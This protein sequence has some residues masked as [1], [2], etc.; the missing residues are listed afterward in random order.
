MVSAL[1]HTYD[2]VLFIGQVKNI[3][4]LGTFISIH[5]LGVLRYGKKKKALI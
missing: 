2:D 3:I 1:F 4:E 5:L